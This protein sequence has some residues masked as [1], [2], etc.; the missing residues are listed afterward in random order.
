MMRPARF[1]R[2]CRVAGCITVKWPFKCTAITA[3]HSSSL[4]LKIIRSRRM[5]AQ[6]TR[7]WRS[8][9]DAMAW[10]MAARPPA[11]VA[12]LWAFATARPP[13]ASISFT[14]AS[15]GALDGSRPSTLTP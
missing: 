5:P 8:P 11:M 7:M 14:T 15:A 12:M 6:Q 13:W 10:S 2:M 4:M 9:N 3:S 1:S